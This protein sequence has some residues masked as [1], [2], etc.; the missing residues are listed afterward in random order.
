MNNKILSLFCGCGGLD[1]GFH[2]A[3][4][5]TALGYDKRSESIASWSLM[6]PHAKGI[7]R[8]IASLTLEQIDADYGS[9]FNPIGLIGG[10][11]CQGFSVA[12]RYGGMHDPRNVLVHRFFD[13]A[14]ELNK[15]S[16]L[17]FIVMENVPALSGKRG[18]DILSAELERLEKE[19]F[20]ARFFVLDAVN[21]GVPQRRR[22]LFLVAYNKRFIDSF[23]NPPAPMDHIVTVRDAIGNLP[24]PVFFGDK[25]HDRSNSFHPNH[26]CMVPRSNKFTSGELYEGYV[27]KR[28]FKTLFWDKPSYTASYGNREI[29]IHPSCS[30]RLSVL[31]AMLIQGFPISVTLKGTLSG[32]IRQVSEAVPPPLAKAVAQS[33]IMQL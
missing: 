14:C 7:I 27:D 26:W 1:L 13:L 20:N 28:S 33:I 30:R 25:L 15:R 8:D 5:E 4:F 17:K 31:E 19:G 11:P 29:H 3:G 21:H 12:N 6:F 16:P 23:W 22:R 9:E 32:Q 24:D 2:Q 10:P 18:G